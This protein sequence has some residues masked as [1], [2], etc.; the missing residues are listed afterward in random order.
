MNKDVIYIEPEDDITDILAN[1][2]SAKNKIV[3]LVPPKKAG[4]LRSAVNFKLIAKTSRQAGKAVVLITSD[5]SLLKLAENVKMPTARTLQSKPKLPSDM[6]TEEFGDEKKDDADENDNEE[7]AKEDDDPNDSNDDD[8]IEEEPKKIPVKKESSAK[9]TATTKR[10]E[11]DLELDDDDLDDDEEEKKPAKKKANKNIPDF[12]KVRTPIIIAVIA[13][14]LIFGIGFWAFNIAP[15]AKISVKIKT[16]AQNFNESITFV[17]DETKAKPED[18]IFFIEQKTL[19]KT[20][21]TEFVATGEVDKGTKATGSITLKAA[22]PVLV[23]LDQKKTISI[24]VGA[25]FTR[26]G[27]SYTASTAT[28]IEISNKNFNGI[29]HCKIVEEQLSCNLSSDASATVNVV[30]TANGEKYNIGETTSGWTSSVTG[31]VVASSSAMTG[32]TSK[33]V[34]VVSQK[35]VETAEAG[36][37]GEG[38]S[39]AREELASQFSN[40]YLLIEK[41]F[42]ATGGKITASPSINEEVKDGIKPKVIKEIKYTIF[43]VKRDDLSKFIEAKTE[44]GDDTQTIYSTGVSS[45][46]GEDNKVYIDSFK[47]EDNK[48][49]G[50]LKTV[51]KTGPEVTEQM[52]SDKS[53]GKKIGEVRSHLKS[54]NGI[55]E[56]NVDTSYFWVTSVPSDPNKVTFEITVE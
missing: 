55:S 52:V 39:D 18:G 56:V 53:L 43:A 21:E 3:A 44:I 25:T 49:V 29:R 41:S 28:S 40:E 7:A 12:K 5:E 34:K 45:E 32:G 48:Y 27:M 50:R 24:P 16:I 14:L 13:I 4:V 38:E 19:T 15:A 31:T 9:A 20:A 54:I 1:I 10:K 8:V 6:D 11:A 51:V 2:K 46:D 47:K 42:T 23:G 37:E 30:A 35:D 26:E 22:S 17:T 36:L 33:K